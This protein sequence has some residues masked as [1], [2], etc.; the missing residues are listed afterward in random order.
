MIITPLFYYIAPVEMNSQLSSQSLAS[1]HD[2]KR[3]SPSLQAG[4]R[5]S[6]SNSH[7]KHSSHG[8]DKHAGEDDGQ[9]ASE[10]QFVYHEVW[11]C[12]YCGLNGHGALTVALQ[13]HCTACQY[14]RCEHCTTEWVEMRVGT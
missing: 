7:H 8:K 5:S 4:H 11:Y 1:D 9:P 13:T 12:C 6:H 2:R 10:P 14:Q 3:K